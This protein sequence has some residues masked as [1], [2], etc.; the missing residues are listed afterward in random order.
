MIYARLPK[1]HAD[2]TRT[3]GLDRLKLIR[4]LQIAQTLT[5]HHVRWRSC[6]AAPQVTNPIPQDPDRVC[7]ADPLSNHRG[8]HRQPRPQQLPDPRLDLIDQ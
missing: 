4:L 5:L 7:P 1:V 2:E 6:L 3:Q 8:R